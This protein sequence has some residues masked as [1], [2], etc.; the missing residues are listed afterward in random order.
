MF[1]DSRRESDGKSALAE[2]YLSEKAPEP[3]RDTGKKTRCLQED[4][5]RKEGTQN[6]FGNKT[7]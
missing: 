4:K 3:E 5:E 2:T 7:H 1:T 6:K